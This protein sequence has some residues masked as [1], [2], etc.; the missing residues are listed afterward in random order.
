MSAVILEEEMAISEITLAL[1][2]D[3]GWYNA[4]YYTG[5]LMR[6]GKNKGCKFLEENCLDNNFKTIFVNEF[7]DLDN[8][9]SPSCSSGR[10][11][12]AYS[13][14][15]QYDSIK[16]YNYSYNFILDENKNSYYSGAVYTADY[17]FVHGCHQSEFFSYFLGNCKYGNG[18]YG[19]NIFYYS[20][21]T[22][23]WENISNNNL[24]KE[25][26]ETYG[27]S[28]FCIMSSL[29]PSGKYAIFGSIFH[30][31]C[32]QMHCSSSFL[33]IQINDDYVVCPREGGNIKLEGYD[34]ELHCPDYNLICTGTVLC[35][36]LFDC[37]EKKSE[38]KTESFYYNYHCLTTNLFNDIKKVESLVG[39]ELS[40]DGICPH[41]YSQCS[42]NKKCKVC[43]N[44]YNCYE[45][46]PRG[47]F[48]NIKN[49]QIFQHPS[50]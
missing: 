8:A 26:G 10:Q 1:L 7:F 45:I 31:M 18:Y 36:D 11:S 12:R 9:N 4:N 13:Y 5:S 24:P 28:S 29:V 6:F 43:Q 48:K 44:G 33:T 14:P 17:C 16:D 38:V 42:K 30:P 35:N 47:V 15:E 19:Q 40:D 37:I 21:E 2:E 49:F 39:Y 34:G 50:V 23:K 25:L 3:S 20:Y 32:Y 22:E 46:Y 27:N 41:Y